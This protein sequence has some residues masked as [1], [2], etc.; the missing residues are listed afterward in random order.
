MPD[1][2]DIQRSALHDHKRFK[3]QLIPPFNRLSPQPE[4]IFWAKDL[5]PEF[6]W[7]DS[8]T[9]EYG[10]RAALSVF[11]EFLSA[12]DPLVSDSC[13]VVDGTV[14]AFGFVP[15]ELRKEFLQTYGGKIE[16]A[17]RKPFGAVVGLYP[18][19]PM[20]W[21]LSDTGGDD[22][23]AVRNAV[24]RLLPGKDSYCARLRVLPITRYFVHKKLKITSNLTELIEALKQ[25]PKGDTAHVESFARN[26]YNTLVGE[27]AKKSPETLKWAKDFWRRN[28]EFAQCRLPEF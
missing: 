5:L 26:V 19:C 6:L 12:I 4:Q 2:I 16:W 1:K 28:T 27:R 13:E 25:Y 24:I 17:V 10:E 15:R 22:I 8:L 23:E 21:L 18:E 14:S 20:R 3:K 9:Q 7:I 11:G